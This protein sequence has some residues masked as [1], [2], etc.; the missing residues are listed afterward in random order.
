MVIAV[1]VTYHDFTSVAAGV[2]TT[3]G[4]GR[5]VLFMRLAWA[6]LPICL[7]G[8]SLGPAQ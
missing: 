3:W 2:C 1:Y 7:S 8:V 4:I 5:T 6:Q